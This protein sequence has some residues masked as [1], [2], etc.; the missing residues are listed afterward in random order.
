MSPRPATEDE[1]KLFHSAE[2]LECLKRLSDEDDD[3]KH[4]EE[5]EMYGLSELIYLT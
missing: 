2:Y 3:E 1:L 5:A 4:G